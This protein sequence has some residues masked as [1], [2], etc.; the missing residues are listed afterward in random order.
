MLVF[1]KILDTYLVDDPHQDYPLSIESV[2]ISQDVFSEK[3]Q[4][5]LTDRKEKFKFTNPPPILIPN[6]Q[7]KTNYVLHYRNLQTYLRHG[8]KLKKVRESILIFLIDY[9]SSGSSFAWN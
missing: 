5:L 2:Q 4:E 6:L 7:N 1:R 3:Q 9:L 8:M